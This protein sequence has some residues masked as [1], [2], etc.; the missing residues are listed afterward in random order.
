MQIYGQLQSP[1]ARD[2]EDMR[3]AAKMILQSS[4]DLDEIIRELYQKKLIVRLLLHS[5]CKWTEI[6]FP[7][8]HKG[9]NSVGDGG[10][11]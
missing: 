7:Q 5:D 3:D 10:L 1:E 9:Y 2:S 11:I 6:H 4:S 8:V